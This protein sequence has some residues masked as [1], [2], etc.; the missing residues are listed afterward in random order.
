MDA[1]QQA[2]AARYVPLA[3]ALAQPE[4]RALPAAACEFE[5]A[6]LLALVQAARSFEPSRQV[7]FAT[8]CRA[9]IRGALKDVRR[10][11]FARPWQFQPRQARD[12]P[13][14]AWCEAIEEVE[15]WLRRL[16]PKH[17]LT[18]RE[19]YIN[20]RKHEEIA[21]LLGC[22][23][24]RVASLHRESLSMLRKWPRNKHT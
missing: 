23:L 2:L 15:R 11:V 14:G 13:I 22:P 10:E 8:Y 12:T 4:Q 17:A 7:G 3:R 5:S 6:A 18:C 20:E 24:S 9:R 16:P 19:I 21:H 1:N